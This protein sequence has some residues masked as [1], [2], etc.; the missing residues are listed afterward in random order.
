MYILQL[1]SIQCGRHTNLYVLWC[2]CHITVEVS[3]SCLNLSY[4]V[5]NLY[6]FHKFF[7]LRSDSIQCIM[8]LTKPL[9]KYYKIFIMLLTSPLT[10]NS[11]LSLAH[12]KKNNCHFFTV[13]NRN[14]L[15]IGLSCSLAILAHLRLPKPGPRVVDHLTIVGLYATLLSLWLVRHRI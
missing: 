9:N 7:E 14:V 1:Q 12:R 6:Y 10:K 5:Y 13:Y 2:I 8:L 3:S 4:I 15:K 11:W